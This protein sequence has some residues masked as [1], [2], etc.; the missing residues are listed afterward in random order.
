M[1]VLPAREDRG[2]VADVR[3]IRAR[4]AALYGAICVLTV[5]IFPVTYKYLVQMRAP[6]VML[7]N[8]RNLLMI[9]LALWIARGTPPRP[10]PAPAVARPA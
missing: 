4:Q 2:L 7:L 1:Q 5:L 6:S 9:V 3:E 8:L 10:A